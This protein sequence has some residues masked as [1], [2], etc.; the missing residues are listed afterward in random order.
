MS[1]LLTE[2]LVI[3]IYRESKKVRNNELRGSGVFYL[4]YNVGCGK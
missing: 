4:K 3:Q 2:V 1:G